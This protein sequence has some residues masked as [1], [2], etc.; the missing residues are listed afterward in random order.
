M[1]SRQRQKLTPRQ[2]ELLNHGLRTRERTIRC[3]VRFRR[4]KSTRPFLRF[5]N[6]E[7]AWRN[8]SITSQ[9][10]IPRALQKKVVPRPRP[11]SQQRAPS[12]ALRLGPHWPLTGLRQRPRELDAF[13]SDTSPNAYEKVVDRLPRSPTPLRRAHGAEWLAAAR[14]RPI[15]A[16]H[17]TATTS[18]PAAKHDAPGANG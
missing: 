5:S 13:L 9:K 17:G 11:S 12:A 1:P 18:T 3:L 14:V 2:I 4:I 16:A 15:R 10:F 7:I 8:P 6:L